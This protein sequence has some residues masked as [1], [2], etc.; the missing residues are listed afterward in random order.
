MRPVIKISLIVLIIAVIGLII[1]FVWSAIATPAPTVPAAVPNP[2][3]PVA[4][5]GGGSE[6]QPGAGN[7]TSSQSILTLSKISENPVFDYWV[8]SQT[9][10]VYYLNPD[11]QVFSAKSGADLQITQ[12]KLSAPNFIDLSPNS[13]RV[14]VAFGD[15]RL[16]Q[17][18]IFDVIDEVWR[19]LP[20]NILN[21]TWGNDSNTLIGFVKNGNNINLSS[22]NISLNPPTYRI[23]SKDVRFQDVKLDSISTSSLI[24]EEN[25]SVGY[26][27]HIW[28]LSLKDLSLN[29]LFSPENGLTIKTSSDKN[30]MF[31]FS[32]SGGFRILNAKTLGL[33][34]PVP[35]STLP[36][37]CSPDSAIIYCF[38]PQDDN[39]RN[40][41]LPDDYFQG[42]FQTKDILYKIDLAADDVEPV[43]LPSNATA[44][45]DARNPQFS[46][47]KLYFI[48]NYD[49]QLYS[50]VFSPSGN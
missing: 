34:I 12:Q 50:L 10:E 23:I 24:I 32:A 15:P 27:G 47:G 16:P 43:V 2:N 11:G 36:S 22:I 38:V 49:D 20:S 4:P 25:S 18:G 48:N 26:A 6:T 29:A 8:D 9:Q 33:A 41:S 45:I 44:P 30:I 35:F 37:K 42:K 5:N 17:W 21:A 14:L 40:A 19:P 7:S 3:L 13:Q 46:A 1:Y 31:V 28:N 39:F